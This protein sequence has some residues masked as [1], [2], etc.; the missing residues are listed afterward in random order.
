MKKAIFLILVLVSLLILL[1]RFGAVPLLGLLNVKEKAGLKIQSTPSAAQ[2]FVDELSVGK[3]PFE[4]DN[5]T[6]GEKIVR[7]EI[8]ENKWQG[9]VK[10]V[11]GTLTV[12]NRDLAKDNTSSAGEILTLEKGAGATVISLPS[13]AMVEIDGKTEGLTPLKIDLTVGEH[14]FVISKGEYLKRGIRVQVP[15][16]F[17]LILT[18]DLAL[19]E[20]DLTNVNFPTVTG[21]SFLVVKNTPTGFLRVRDKPSLSGAEVTRVSP[22]DE[23][24]L[25]EEGSSWDKI[26]LPNGTEGYV[27]TSYVEKKT[28]QAP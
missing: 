3:T 1:V 20:T 19:T 23:L 15:A 12:I 10:L 27:S 25:L 18:V 21:T 22:G 7:L 17:N 13:E 2:V 26:R 14:T 11:E 16:G 9:Q 8:G 4:E 28:S 24:I 6:P 5:F